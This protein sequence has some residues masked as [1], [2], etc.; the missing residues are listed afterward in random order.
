MKN[1]IKAE[2]SRRQMT[3]QE[4]A[5]ALGV[6]RQAVHAI[7]SGKFNPSTVLSLKISQIFGK[8]VNEIFFLDEEDQ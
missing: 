5:D 1:N 2:R 4:L 8:Q 7:E 3:Q 6:S